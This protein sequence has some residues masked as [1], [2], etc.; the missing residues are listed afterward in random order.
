M[1]LTLFAAIIATIAA[2][3]FLALIF[4]NSESFGQVEDRLATSKLGSVAM[5]LVEVSGK[6]KAIKP[7]TSPFTKTRCVAYQH[8]VS[9]WDVKRRKSGNKISKESKVQRFRLE[10]SSGSVIVDSGQLTAHGVPFVHR[11]V[12]KKPDFEFTHKEY[13]LR[14]NDEVMVIGRAESIDGETIIKHDSET[15]VF[16]VRVM[17]T[18][19]A[20]RKDRPLMKSFGYTLLSLIMITAIMLVA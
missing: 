7:L 11:K 18:V 4:S 9:E 2:I 15:N 17:A 20:D 14:E 3:I 6:V 16:E 5:G 8:T 10:D 12:D 1:T 13:L 19:Q